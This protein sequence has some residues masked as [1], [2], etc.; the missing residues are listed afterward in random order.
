MNIGPLIDR[1]IVAGLSPGEAGS[2]AAE[3]Y[4]AGVASVSRCSSNA[5]RQQRYR[6]RKRNET[7]T[8][9]NAD[10]QVTDRNNV[11]ETVTNRNETVTRYGDS[12]TYLSSLKVSK[13]E[14]RKKET[15]E[16]ALSEDWPSDC[17]QAFWK[18]WPHKVGKPAALK[19]LR[20]AL[21][22]ATIAE[23]LEG[24]GNYIRDKP[25]DRHWLNPATFLNQ[26][27]WEDQ[28][29]TV[30]PHAKPKSAIIQAADDLCQKIA[31][32]DG[33]ARDP[34]E[35]RSGEGKNPPRLLSYR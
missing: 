33:P 19:A 27:R 14:E 22:R 1:M 31:S 23:I 28:P 10:K 25:P 15:R 30:S 8:E 13:K 34:D 24:V 4:A 3:I 32:F 20:S 18:L 17:M 35:I 26:S 5:A 29:A 9:R 21:K 11:T 12:L 2:I 7:V 6:D 16:T